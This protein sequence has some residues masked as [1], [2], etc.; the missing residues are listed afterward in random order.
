MKIEISKTG[1]NEGF[2]RSDEKPDPK[3]FEVDS[4]ISC[5][6]IETKQGVSRYFDSLEEVN[7]SLIN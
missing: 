3:K 4:K 5:E 7:I 6:A 1:I 2:E